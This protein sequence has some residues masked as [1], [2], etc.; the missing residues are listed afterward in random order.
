MKRIV[1]SGYYGFGNVGDEAVLAGTLASF[2][3]LNADVEITVLS[4][5][6]A[7]TTAVHGVA[8]LPRYSLSAVTQAIR[9]SDLLLSGGG[10]L[11]QDV[12]SARSA[13]YYFGVIALAELLR[14]P[15]MLYAQGVGPITRTVT[16]LQARLLLNRVALASVRDADSADLLRRLGVKRPP[17]HVTADPSFALDPATEEETDRL[18][19][20][21]DIPAGSALLGV[22]VRQWNAGENWPKA[23]AKGVDEAARLTGATPVFIPMHYPADVEIAEQ[24][25]GELSVRSGRLRTRLTPTQAKGVVGRMDVLLGMRLHALMF[26]AAQGTPSVAL[27]YDPKVTSF[28]TGAPGHMPV[29]NV[30]SATSEEIAESLERVWANRA[31]IGSAL[32][33]AQP[34]WRAEAIRNSALALEL[35]K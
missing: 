21:A 20:E 32:S 1:V 22:A 27:S 2:R 8:S 29:I 4:G 13:A 14:V 11:L 16:A 23:V 9:Q 10:S 33:S 24:L 30:G 6:P 19:A 12:S 3:S 7:D 28:A 35:L 25:A 15:V 26:A 5:D 34:Y 31:A 18:L 17:I